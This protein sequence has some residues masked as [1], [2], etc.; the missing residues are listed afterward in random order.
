MLGF[1]DLQTAAVLTALVAVLVAYT[2]KVRYDI[3]PDA[4]IV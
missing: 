3:Q 4:E 2:A 1:G